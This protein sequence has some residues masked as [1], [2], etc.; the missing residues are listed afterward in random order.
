MPESKRGK[1]TAV[2][3]PVKRQRD[4]SRS[5]NP[6]WQPLRIVRPEPSPPTCP[7]RQFKRYWESG[8]RDNGSGF[9]DV[10][11]FRRK[12]R[13]QI[14]LAPALVWA[15]SQSNSVRLM[16]VTDCYARALRRER[17]AGLVGTLRRE[18]GVPRTETEVREI[19][20]AAESTVRQLSNLPAP[21]PKEKKNL[22][23]PESECEEFS[24]STTPQEPRPPLPLHLSAAGPPQLPTGQEFYSR[25]S[26]ES[27]RGAPLR[28]DV[29][30]PPQLPSG[31]KSS[32]R[33][34]GELVRGVPERF[35]ISTPLGS[36]RGF[37][38]K[39]AATVPPAP[40]TPLLRSKSG[41]PA[42]VR[43]SGSKNRRLS[44]ARAQAVAP[45]I[46]R[47]RAV[48]DGGSKTY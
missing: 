27:V 37:S 41:Y 45:Y 40:K 38:P 48:A 29:S 25:K 20:A 42:R 34:S 16:R 30:V 2:C 13:F 46:Q 23:P 36:V 11:V 9:E 32:S 10:C 44:A 15:D 8:P 26:G 12:E 35:D 24:P 28:Q 6:F 47:S 4:R 19:P 21:R 43:K 17:T 5:R 31:Q 1:E 33:R 39:T 14:Y 3:S 22:G 7:P 18:T